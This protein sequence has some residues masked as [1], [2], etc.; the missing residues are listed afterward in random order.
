MVTNHWATKPEDKAMIL[1]NIERESSMR[2]LNELVSLTMKTWLLE[3]GR[4]ASKKKVVDYL[5]KKF[6]DDLPRLLDKLE[7]ELSR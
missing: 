2:S 4:R 1:A 6:N 5:Y 7:E 3:T